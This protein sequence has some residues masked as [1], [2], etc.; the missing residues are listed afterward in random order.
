MRKKW[1]KPFENK[2]LTSKGLSKQ[3]IA[4]GFELVSY[5]TVSRKYEEKRQG[6]EK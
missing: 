5:E 3:E 1:S 6:K 4:L 2:V